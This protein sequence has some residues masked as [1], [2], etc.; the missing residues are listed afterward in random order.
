MQVDPF[1]VRY[2]P[3]E[4][5]EEGIYIVKVFAAIESRFFWEMSW[6]VY[7]EGT[8][9]WYK[10]DFATKMLFNFNATTSTFSLHEIQNEIDLD[11]PCYRCTRIATRSWQELQD[12]GPTAFW[13]LVVTGAPYYISDYQARNLKMFGKVCDGITTY[14]CYQ[15]LPDGVYILRLGGGLFG[16]LTGFPYNNASWEGCGESGTL[17]DQL[18]RRF[19]QR[20]CHHHYNHHHQH[21]DLHHHHQLL[22]LLLPLSL[23]LLFHFSTDLGGLA[24]AGFPRGQRRV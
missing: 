23:L 18:V 13:P 7:V 3:Y 5:E 2:C 24:A 14:E 11:A 1:Y 20:R 12:S 9:T 19:I 8:D 4:A 17:H 22:L 10:G 6:Q 21:H 16:R 15:T